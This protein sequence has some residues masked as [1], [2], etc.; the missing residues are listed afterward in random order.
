MFENFLKTPEQLA[1]YR[2]GPLAEERARYLEHLSSEGRSLSRLQEIN[3]RLLSIAETIDPDR[4]RRYAI[5]DLADLAE[6]WLAALPVDKRP[7]RDRVAKLDFQFVASIWLRFLGRLNEAQPAGPF[8]SEVSEFLAHL[9]RDRGY[10]QTTCGNRQRSLRPF[11]NWLNGCGVPLAD[12]GPANIS[13]FFIAMAGRWSR[14]TVAQHV[15]ALRSFFRYA[16]SR[17]WCATGI[18]E[19]IDAPRLYTH[20]NL[21]QGP[22]WADVQKLVASTDGATIDRIRERAAILLLTTYGLRAGEVCHLRI[23]DVDW[24]RETIQIRRSKQRK[25]QTY[26]LTTETGNA[27]LRYLEV[28]PRSPRRE[29]FLTLRQP[30]RPVSVGGFSSLIQKRQK[31]LGLKLKRYGPH[32]LRH[33]CATHLLAEGFSLKEVGDHLG[34][35]S[36]TAT[37]VYAKVNL[38]SLR[39]VAAF[40]LSGLDTFL[41][42]CEECETPF[43]VAGDLAAL[44]AVARRSLEGLA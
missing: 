19:A 24:S 7:T 9:E 23:D 12:V 41:R 4:E 3:R 22:P 35:V 26:P 8:A 33:A 18:A 30:Y 5:T 1:R 32:G 13:A 44:R 27:L 31:Q 38:Q 25:S 37:Q 14:T 21:P 15:Q 34:H 10:S 39:S 29:V 43:Y 42:Q 11:L 40:G 20:E 17:D 36:A 16:A 28:R 6:R 2:G